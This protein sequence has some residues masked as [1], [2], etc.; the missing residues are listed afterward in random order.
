[1]VKV[2]AGLGA[3]ALLVS[4][5]IAAAGL[6]DD[7][8]LSEPESV[9][10]SPSPSTSALSP[11][12]PKSPPAEKEPGSTRPP[13]PALARFYHQ[14]VEWKVCERVYECARVDVPLD[15]D[16]PRA[17]TI[18][19]ALLRFPAAVPSKRLGSLVVNPGGP[20]APGTDW[21]RGATAA[22]RTPVLNRYDIV[23][24]DPRGIGESTAIDCASDKTLDTIIAS[25]PTP[26]TDAERRGFVRLLREFGSGCI[27]RS[28]DLASHVST[29][30]SARDLDVIRAALGEARLNFFGASYGTV[31]GAFY[32]ELF[33]NRVGRLVLD[34]AVSLGGA[35]GRLTGDQAA[36]FERALRAYVR[37]CMRT[38][39]DPCV[40]YDSVDQGVARIG[41]FL[42]RVERTPLPA[43]YGRD[44]RAGN[45]LAGVA[46]GL[47]ARNSWGY[48]SS[49]LEAAF[50]GDGMFLLQ[51]SDAYNSRGPQ[52]YLDNSMEAGYA[53][54]CLDNPG[55]TSMTRV[56][57]GIDRLERRS[58]TFGAAFG[59]SLLGCQGMPRPTEEPPEVDGAGAAPIVVI[60]TTGD[61]ATPY[62]W[63]ESLAAQLDSGVL[64]SRDGDGHTGY[65]RG[66]ACVDDAVHAY[67]LEGTVPDDGLSC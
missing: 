65:H 9:A 22:F 51:M 12:P 35:S 47:Y 11:A 28:G 18:S 49:A 7:G 39:T 59:W 10:A 31:L 43:L 37:N 38:N 30:E 8:R 1:V 42:A 25:D 56:R 32:A 16:R 41:R 45:A 19:L 3:S 55:R 44:L 58:P 6:G 66:N 20:G 52:G 14:S 57:R 2:L 17:T 15:Y 60:G 48:L 40:L 63:A 54:S 61:P 5:G 34:G 50:H 36:G 26:D 67:L 64:V 21:A 29:A 62:E 53:I 27:R 4:G 24:F 23:G 13:R 33:P 46:A